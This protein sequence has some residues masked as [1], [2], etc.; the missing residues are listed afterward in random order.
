MTS[1]KTERQKEILKAIQEGIASNE[2]R[3]ELYESVKRLCWGIAYKYQTRLRCPDELEDL[4]QEAYFAV[5]KAAETYDPEGGKAFAG[6]LAFYLHRS[7][8]AYISAQNGNA[9]GCMQLASK[10]SRYEGEYF[11]IMGKRPSDK[12]ICFIFDITPDKL[13]ALRSGNKG[14]LSLD[15][16]DEEGISL[17][18]RIDSSGANEGRSLEDEVIDKI[19]MEEA[20]EKLREYIDELNRDER[21]AII[22]YYFRNRTDRECSALMDIAQGRFTALRHR[23]LHKL[24]SAKH[25]AELGRLLPDWLGSRPYNSRGRWTSSTEKSAMLLFEKG[26]SGQTPFSWNAGPRGIA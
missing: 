3:A 2:D 4:M 7:Y 5:Q 23:A 16:E 25:R 24:R 12:T 26:S 22:L 18:D 15:Q 14:P 19:A 21:E 20:S 13:A 9:A 17:F 10:I 6:W 11:S 1:A 8:S